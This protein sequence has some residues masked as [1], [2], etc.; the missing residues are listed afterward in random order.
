MIRARRSE[1][2]ASLVLVL[3]LV[4][5][6]LIP[7]VGQLGSAS[8]VATHVVKSQRF[9]ELS[10]ESSVQAAIAWARRTRT[11][12]R[13]S[14]ACPSFNADFP[15][16][17]GY[18]RS[19]TVRCRGF[20]GSGR[21]Q[22]GP[23][24]P[25]YALLTT[26]TGDDE[27]GVDVSGGPFRTE[28]PL[29]SD[30]GQQGGAPASFT[31]AGLDNRDHLV[32]GVGP[33]ATTNGAPVLG[34]PDLC[35]SGTVVGDPGG[36]GD[37]ATGKWASS[38]QS[39]D[40]VPLRSI[41]DDVCDRIP[42]SRVYTLQPGFYYDGAG[43]EALTNRDAP[44][45]CGDVVLWLRPGPGNTVG[46]FSFDLSFFE[47]VDGTVWRMNTGAVVGGAPSGWDPAA[48]TSQVNQVRALIGDE[49]SCN[50][51]RNGVELVFGDRSRVRVREPAKLELCAA[52]RGETEVGQAISISGRKTG[53]APTTSV[54]TTPSTVTSAAFTWPPAQPS[55]DPLRVADCGGNG[56][57]VAGGSITGTLTGRRDM[58][59][60]AM[61]LPYQV[62]DGV[63]L[64]EFTLEVRHREAEAAAGDLAE[65]T[66]DLTGLPDGYTCDVSNV[67][68]SIGAWR[69]DTATCTANNAPTPAPGGRPSRRSS[70]LRTQTATRLRRQSSWTT[71]RS[72]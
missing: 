28:G 39:I 45:F 35:D 10:A 14:V 25:T 36:A 19:V 57:C 59:E 42:A 15:R 72:T 18:S 20:A 58:G 22:E 60:I 40:D 70:R 27:I 71:C 34:A 46:R 1:S 66:L 37:P 67:R 54:S 53:G 49:G 11:A 63:R 31:N 17:D 7:V 50:M 65:L 12:G 44:S 51:A 3:V 68:P 52:A 62:A 4:F 30:S 69:T 47:P 21:V 8:S 29:W 5:G 13:G 26:A 64:D 43:L 2:G 16:D 9:D 48:A 61:A 33:C 32:G 23:N 56:P 38:V 24:T 55:A 41:P 6:M